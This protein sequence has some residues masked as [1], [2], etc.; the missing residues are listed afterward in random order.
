MRDRPDFW[1]TSL[2][3]A[4]DYRASLYRGKIHAAFTSLDRKDRWRSIT[5]NKL[6]SILLDPA[7]DSVFDKPV[8]AQWLAKLNRHIDELDSFELLEN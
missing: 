8:Q 7:D 4:S 6:D 2:T 1:V 5:G 3:L